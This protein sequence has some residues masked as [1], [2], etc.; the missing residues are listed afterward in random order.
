MRSPWPNAALSRSYE[1]D[2]VLTAISGDTG[3]TDASSARVRWADVNTAGR[4]TGP[5]WARVTAFSGGTNNRWV[6]AATQVERTAGG[7]ADVSG[8]VA[9]AGMLNATESSNTGGGIEGHGGD[10]TA[11]DEST[12]ELLPIRGGPVVMC[13]PTLI[14]GTI[15][16]TF[17]QSNFE[18]PTCV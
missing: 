4:G 10:L 17:A 13:W 2:E 9:I 1:V 14:S 18:L 11:T 8:G 3:L 16:W 7:W 15:Y 6:Y 5:I 12:F